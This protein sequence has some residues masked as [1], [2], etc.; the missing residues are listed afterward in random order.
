MPL[1]ILF[2]FLA[3][4]FTILSPCIL[5][6]LPAILS[7]GTTKGRLR[8]LG[9]ILGLIIS[10]TFFTLALTAIVHATGLS[11][12]VLRY[13]AIA[14]IALFGIIMIFP[15]LSDWFSRITAP[16][17]NVGQNLQGKGSATGFG[18][19]FIFGVALGLL[20]TPCAGPI[21][22]AITTLVATQSV[23]F[24]I[25][26]ITLA[27]SIGA[28]I[29]MFL[30]AYGSGKIIQSSKF[31]SSR[32]EGIRQIF[33]VLMIL[34]AVAIGLHWDMILQQKVSSLFPTI[35]LEDNALVKT[36]IEKLRG[37]GSD[38]MNWF[39]IPDKLSNFGP[40]PEF[41]GVINWINSPPLS[42]MKLKDKVVL[43][44]FW[45]YSCINCL[46][47]LPYIEKW[48]ADYKDK[49]FVVVGVHTPE[50]EF[51]KDPSNVA[52][53]ASRLGVEY[54][55]AQDNDYKTWNA[56]HNHYWPAHYLI[57]KNG[58]LRMVHF[59]EGG[60]VETENAIRELLGLPVLSMQEPIKSVRPLSPETYLGTLRGHNYSSEIEVKPDQS[61]QYNYTN[62]L[63]EDKV[64]LKGDWKVEN[65][66]IVSEGSDSYLDLN[67]L[68]KQVYLVL[69]GSSKTPIQ[70]YLDDKQVGTI[71]VD[72][73]RKYDIVDTSY[74]R[75]KLSLKIPEGIS[76][77]A[78]T[79]GDD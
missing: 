28:A 60:Y 75:H 11:P 10:F 15:S 42:L 49:G 77:Y 36:Q 55:I 1:L 18:G 66:R 9:I 7:A 19:G 2:A 50:F 76:A 47:T 38:E 46:R 52:G 57:D 71:E 32:A 29:P 53:A 39:V 45:T 8:P 35:M 62:T 17:A 14:L 51:E 69:S 22:A 73:A 65:E 78:F 54:P 26:L 23:N 33:G 70:V 27:Y 72:G 24:S 20:W 40:A 4:I 68:A 56:F 13:A 48:Y 59:G 31:L 30:L 6:I 25:I 67:F 41:T 44:D 61:A 5:P 74:G 63:P 3:G 37:E 58:N 12:N 64:G 34:T 79:F 21:L 43:I 16:I